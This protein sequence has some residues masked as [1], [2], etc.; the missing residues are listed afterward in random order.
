MFDPKHEMKNCYVPFCAICEELVQEQEN[1]E[2]YISAIEG[3]EM[4]EDLELQLE[5]G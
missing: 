3:I 1:D 5:L 2:I 4:R